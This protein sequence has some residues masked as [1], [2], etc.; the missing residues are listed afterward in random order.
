M[1]AA[2]V[3]PQQIEP[4]TTSEP[5]ERAAPERTVPEAMNAEEQ[6]RHAPNITAHPRAAWRVAQSK[7]WGGIVGFALG[8]YV[9]LAHH[10][11]PE[12]VFR[13]L[14]TGVVCYI[15]VWAA[16]VFLWRRLVVAELNQAEH[17]LIG[18]ERNQ[19]PAAPGHAS[20]D[21]VKSGAAGR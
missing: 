13:G 4:A 21:D 7:A 5:R 10:T 12:A 19:G 8:T 18:G 14:L 2:E 11:L 20:D 17:A 15:A 16:A 3:H 6:R 9:S 1:P